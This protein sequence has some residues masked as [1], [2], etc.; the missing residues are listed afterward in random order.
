MITLVLTDLNSQELWKFPCAQLPSFHEVA[1][2]GA[3]SISIEDT[4]KV[5]GDFLGIS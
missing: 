4:E 1:G 3:L 2:M 5:G